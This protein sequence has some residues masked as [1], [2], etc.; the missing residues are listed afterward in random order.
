MATR[1]ARGHVE[2]PACGRPRRGLLLRGRAGGPPLA[3]AGEEPEEQ[4]HL[5]A[6][7]QYAEAGLRARHAAAGRRSRPRSRRRE[8]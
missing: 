4:R 6:I 5:G 1:H 8:Y 7:R 2:L 3:P